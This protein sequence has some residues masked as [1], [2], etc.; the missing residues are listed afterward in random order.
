MLH[1]TN[2]GEIAKAH[3]QRC[4]LSQQQV[5]DVLGLSHRSDISR[6]EAGQSGWRLDEVMAFAGLVGVRAS[7]LIAELEA[8]NE[9]ST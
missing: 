1:V 8:S 3:R 5:C 9:A 4:G 6:R 2:F 7:E